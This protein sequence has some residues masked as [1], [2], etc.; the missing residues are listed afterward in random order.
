MLAVVIVAVLVCVVAAAYDKAAAP[1]KL[2]AWTFDGQH[3][4][5]ERPNRPNINNI[6]SNNNPVMNVNTQTLEFPQAVDQLHVNMGMMAQGP[7]VLAMLRL[8]GDAASARQFADHMNALGPA[9]SNVLA[10]VY[11]TKA[12]AAADAPVFDHMQKTHAEMFAHSPEAKELTLEQLRNELAHK[13]ERLSPGE[14]SAG[15]LRNGR[16]DRYVVSINSEAPHAEMEML[17]DIAALSDKDAAVTFVAVH[18]PAENAF[19]PQQLSSYR[20]MLATTTGGAIGTSSYLPE[21]SEYSI[22]S[23]GKYLYITPDIFTAL[24]TMLFV[25][26]VIL[27]GLGCLGAIQGPSA[28]VNKAPIV[29]REA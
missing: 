12:M 13:H 19:A 25:F 4:P 18:E 10:N 5:H 11:R 3:S 7:E 28:F 23:Q 2:M 20:R 17:R 6:H 26:F 9:H 29:G 21:G 15:P 8:K 16:T 1:G 24:M 22:Y 27:T 14:L